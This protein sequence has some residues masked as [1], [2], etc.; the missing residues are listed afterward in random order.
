ME[1]IYKVDNR[2]GSARNPANFLFGQ[3]LGGSVVG[4]I[5]WL[6]EI[7]IVRHY[8]FGWPGLIELEP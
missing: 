3:W 2:T 1:S 5:G 7:P 8:K 4:I 6:Q